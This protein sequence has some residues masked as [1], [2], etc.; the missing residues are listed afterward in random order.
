MGRRRP[1]LPPVTHLLPLPLLV[2]A[3][4]CH[5]PRAFVLALGLAIVCGHNLLD[6]TAMEAQGLENSFPPYAGAPPDGALQLY[7]FLHVKGMVFLP[8]LGTDMFRV[9]E[10]SVAPAGRK[11]KLLILGGTGFLGPATVAAASVRRQ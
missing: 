2:L 3:L 10:R 7:M 6:G 9:P 1:I 8:L 5:L 11:L 4:L